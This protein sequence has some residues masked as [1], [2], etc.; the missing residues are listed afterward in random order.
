MLF[1]FACRTFNGSFWLIY[2]DFQVPAVRKWVENGSRWSNIKVLTPASVFPPQ[3][4]F[5]GEFLGQNVASNGLQD[6]LWD[7]WPIFRIFGVLNVKKRVN[8]DRY[9]NSDITIVFLGQKKLTSAMLQV[10]TIL[11]LSLTAFQVISENFHVF[12]QV[13]QNIGGKHTQPTK[14]FTGNIL[15]PSEDTQGGD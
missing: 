3:K 14:I 1:S 10:L 4:I 6:V 11:I 2:P 15:N 7:F 13:P 12:C 5:Q 9:E 8:K